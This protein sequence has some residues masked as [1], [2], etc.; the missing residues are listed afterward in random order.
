MKE[1]LKKVIDVLSRSKIYV[2]TFMISA[3][4]ISLLYIF[5]NVAPLGPKSLLCVDFYHQYGPM[6][7]ELYD[8]MHGSGGFIYSF[9]MGL[10]LPFFRNFLNY[11]SSPFN[12]I[13]MLFSRNNLVMSYS[14]IIGLKA[15]MASVT[16]VYFLSHKFKTKELFLIP[17]GIIYAFSAYYSAYYWNIMW[18]DCLVFLPLITLGIEYI[19]DKGKWKIYTIWLAVMLISNYFMGY[20]ICIF[21]VLYF[22]VYNI[23]EFNPKKGEIKNS[24]K[25]FIKSCLLFALGSITAGLLAAIL[26][27]PMAHSMKSIS[28]T[29]G[30]MPKTQYYKFTMEDYLKYHLTGV[31]TT[32][33][34]SDSIT[35]PNVS[36]GILSVVLLISFLLNLNIPIKTKICYLFLLGFFVAAFFNPQLDFVL[37]AFHVPNDLPYRYSYLY[38]FVL[39]LIGSYAAVNLHKQSYIQS[40]ITYI[41]MM[42]MLVTLTRETWS[43]M[44]NNMIYINMILLT[45]Y[46]IFYSGGHFMKE[47]KSIFFIALGCAAAIDVIVSINYNWNIT[48]ELKTFYADYDSTE[49]VLQYVR[50]YDNTPFYRIDTVSNMTLNDPSW[51]NYYGVSTFSSMAYQSMARLQYKLG[52]PGNQINSYYYTQTTPVYDLMFDIKYFIGQSN[53]TNR[54]TE[55]YDSDKTLNQFKY[56]VGLG[57]GVNDTLTSWN[58]DIYDPLTV[59]NEYIYKSTGIDDVFE[60]IDYEDEEEVYNDGAEYIMKYTYK[61]PGDNMYFYTGN[62][63]IDF[64]VIGETLY[65]VNDNYQ[66]YVSLVPDMYYSV[67]DSYSE[68]TIINIKSSD[69]TIPIYIG[70]NTYIPNAYFL[71]SINNTNFEQAYKV[72]NNNK[73]V[74]TSFKEDHIEA[75]ISTDK[76]L[77]YT[78]IPYDDGWEVYVDDNKVNTF[79]IGNTLLAFYIEPG[80]HKLVFKY[81]PKG[82]KIGILGTI[83]GIFILLSDKIFNLIKPLFKT[84]KKS[85]NKKK[86]K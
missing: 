15:V 14:I 83:L 30:T 52:M 79:K 12:L 34:A 27:V 5:N 11:L 32:T 45:L 51:Y 39:V 23:H 62:Y 29:G 65:Y 74:I 18:L 77:V 8:R 66:S 69:D 80:N 46:F 24:I 42:V 43:G 41:F 36:A 59:Q 1:V 21:S 81:V 76:N 68:E 48:Q 58:Y 3:F 33:F 4:I 7:G 78:S 54:Y 22:I 49:E 6:L 17:L 67:L 2:I 31:P 72:L 70:Y 10:G 73:M 16:F 25:K 84:K 75:N 53:D 35:A 61:N 82:A 13:I 40:I 9:S 55:I 71:Y 86:R 44:N 85:T 38:T 64:I 37:H 63:A 26:L 57:Y 50:N 20:M 56:N 60:R 28:A 19:V 47:L